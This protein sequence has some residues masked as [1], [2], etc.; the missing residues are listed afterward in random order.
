MEIFFFC[1]SA[2]AY[3]ALLGPSYEPH[4]DMQCVQTDTWFECEILAMA[5]IDANTKKLQPVFD[6]V[7][8][9]KTRGEQDRPVRQEVYLNTQWPPPPGFY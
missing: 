8:C 4:N 7:V 2:T 6:L 5:A 3:G 9:T 1:L